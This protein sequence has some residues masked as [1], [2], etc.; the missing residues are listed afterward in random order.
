MV[1]RTDSWRKAKRSG[2]A[3][4]CLEVKAVRDE[5]LVRDSKNQDFVIRFGNSAWMGFLGRIKE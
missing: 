5:M 1:S 2:A 4:D 3:G